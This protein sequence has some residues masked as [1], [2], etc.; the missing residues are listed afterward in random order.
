MF[1]RLVVTGES[2]GQVWCDD[3]DQGGLSPGPAFYDWYTAWLDA[4]G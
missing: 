2:A 3:P 1:S 4:T